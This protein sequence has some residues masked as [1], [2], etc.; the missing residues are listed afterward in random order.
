MAIYLNLVFL[1]I[2]K[3]GMVF[4]FLFI[5]YLGY[6]NTGAHCSVLSFCTYLY[7]PTPKIPLNNKYVFKIYAIEIISHYYISFDPIQL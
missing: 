7:Y 1:P 6:W 5:Y 2:Y 3:Y 4:T